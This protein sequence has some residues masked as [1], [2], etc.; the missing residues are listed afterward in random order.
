MLF[1]DEPGGWLINDGKVDMQRCRDLWERWHKSPTLQGD[2]LLVSEVLVSLSPLQQKSSRCSEPMREAA[3]E[4]FNKLA[5]LIADFFEYN[6][7]CSSRVCQGALPVRRLARTPWARS[8]SSS[9]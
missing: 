2:F 5:T 8:C 9:G 3:R 4:C 7:T 1:S 6:F